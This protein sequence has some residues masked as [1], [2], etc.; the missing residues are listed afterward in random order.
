MDQEWDN[1]II[2]DACR[3]DLFSDSKAFDVSARRVQSRGSGSVEFM[4][5]NFHGR[6]LHDTVY[7]SANPFTDRLVG[8]GVFH[9]IVDIYN[10]GW[11]ENL[12]TARP[13]TVVEAAIEAHDRFPNKRLIVHFMQP[14]FPF[15][16]KQGQKIDHKGMNKGSSI[17]Y[18]EEGNNRFAIWSQLQFGFADVSIEEVWN[19]YRENLEIVAPH[20]ES[21]V[22]SLN[23]KSVITA[24]HGNLVGERVSPLPVSLFGHPNGLPIPELIDVP[25]AEYPFETRREVLAEPPAGST[26]VEQDVIENRLNDLGYM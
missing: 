11:D 15:I 17:D 18:E 3:Y 8:K 24:D 10:T 25:W 7:V 12:K 6:T 5:E 16:G 26:S 2:L 21:L 23:G 14:H 19:A 20:A 9:D 22:S 13:E 4:E 1:L